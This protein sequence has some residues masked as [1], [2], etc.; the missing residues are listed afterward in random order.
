MLGPSKMENFAIRFNLFLCQKKKKCMAIIYTK[1]GC[2]EPSFDAELF[3]LA[4]DFWLRFI[5]F[6]VLYFLCCLPDE[7]TQL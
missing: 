1:G 6:Q 7:N 3:L 2:A 5:A 4:W